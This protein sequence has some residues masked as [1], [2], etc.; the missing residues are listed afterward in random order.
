MI[1]QPPLL[2]F[3]H[4]IAHSTWTE[5]GHE[6]D[7]LRVAR[8]SPHGFQVNVVDELRIIPPG[9]CGAVDSEAN[10]NTKRHKI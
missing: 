3:W 5:R 8:I 7:G 4:C 2:S 1:P 6:D 9:T 10:L